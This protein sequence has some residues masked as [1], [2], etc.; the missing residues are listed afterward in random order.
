MSVI[1]LQAVAPEWGHWL[2]GG[3]GGGAKGS[4]L[5][6]WKYST[7]WSI[8]TCIHTHAHSHTVFS[9]SKMRT[10]YI[11]LGLYSLCMCICM[12][13]MY[14]NIYIN[15]FSH[16]LTLIASMRLPRVKT[17]RIQ[18]WPKGCQFH[19]RVWG[20][21]S[22]VPPSPS[23]MWETKRTKVHCE[24]RGE[25]MLDF[26]RLWTRKYYKVYKTPVLEDYR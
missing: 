11:L 13:D 2:G 18:R 17:L 24:H 5:G 15:F 23:S 22:R 4:S 1:E 19:C 12:Y 3:G 14:M 10:F 26:T 6:G 9:P 16:K 25:K 8:Y 20:R 7:S 21:G